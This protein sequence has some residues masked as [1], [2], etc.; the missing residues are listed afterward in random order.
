[1][2]R[3]QKGARLRTN[4]TTE[5]GLKEL[6]TYYYIICILFRV[7]ILEAFLSEELEERDERGVCKRTRS[8]DIG[9]EFG[10][11][12]GRYFVRRRVLRRRVLESQS[13]AAAR[14]F[15]IDVGG[16]RRGRSAMR[17]IF[18]YRVQCPREN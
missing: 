12:L 6:N 16:R 14:A 3:R 8:S 10:D 7:S 1:M 13:D 9:K 15:R 18:M 4:V 17:T 2:V 11:R 5:R